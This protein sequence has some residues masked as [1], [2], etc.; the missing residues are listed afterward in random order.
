MLPSIVRWRRGLARIKK[1]GTLVLAIIDPVD[2]RISGLVP[3]R[4]LSKLLRML[5][6]D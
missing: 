6:R 3:L 5:E 1:V 4:T 2:A